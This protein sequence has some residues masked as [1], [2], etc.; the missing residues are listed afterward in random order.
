MGPAAPLDCL[1]WDIFKEFM[2]GRWRWGYQ[3]HCQ[4]LAILG[5]R[6][7]RENHLYLVVSTKVLTQKVAVRQMQGTGKPPAQEAEKEA[8]GKRP[9]SLE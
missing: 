4:R 2:L 3:H 9:G 5:A 8:G 7:N 6:L 1:G